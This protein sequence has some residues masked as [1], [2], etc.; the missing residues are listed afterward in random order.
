MPATINRKLSAVHSFLKWAATNGHIPGAAERPEMSDRQQLGI[1]WLDEKE[2]TK[3]DKALE[4]KRNRLHQALIRFDLYTGLRCSELAELQWSDITIK[5]R[6]GVANVRKGKGSK[7][8]EVPLGYEA[9]TALALIDSKSNLGS[10]DKV[11]M[12]RQGPLT[13][14]GIRFIVSGY[15]ELARLPDLT[16]HVLRH[17]FAKNFLRE[18]NPIEEL[19][20]ILGHEDV[21]TTMIYVVPSIEELPEEGREYGSRQEEAIDPHPRP[22]PHPRSRPR[23]ISPKCVIHTRNILE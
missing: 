8:R 16:T 18:G 13:D 21:N 14:R 7:Y 5:E 23:L 15:A 4:L 20:R 19:A 3:L 11:F 10:H 1:R 17:T 22:N 9:R 12:G 2:Q 6:S